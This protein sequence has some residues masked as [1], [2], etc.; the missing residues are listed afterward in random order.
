MY[1]IGVAQSQVGPTLPSLKGHKVL[2]TYASNNNQSLVVNNNN[3]SSSSSSSSK[4]KHDVGMS[5]S[6]SA[7]VGKGSCDTTTTGSWGDTW[8]ARGACPVGLQGGLCGE[9]DV[10]LEVSQRKPGGQG[11]AH[12][13]AVRAVLDRVRAELGSEEDLVGMRQGRGYFNF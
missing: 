13:D 3:N 12:S 8:G 6:E 2:A 10:V 1:G 9:E 5:S 11:Q 4:E 7:S